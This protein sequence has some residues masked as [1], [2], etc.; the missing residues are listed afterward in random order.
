MNDII[1]LV[2]RVKHKATV[3]TSVRLS[4]H[5]SVVSPK[6]AKLPFGW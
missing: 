5:L 3:L 2:A 6:I 1:M 4:V